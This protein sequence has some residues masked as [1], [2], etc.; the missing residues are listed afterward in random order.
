MEQARRIWEEEGLPK[1]RLKQPWFGYTLGLW[2]AEDEASAEWTVKGE[3]HKVGEHALT[4]Q[5]PVDEILARR[6]VRDTRRRE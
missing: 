1:L 4:G 6:T 2:T 3:Y 5:K